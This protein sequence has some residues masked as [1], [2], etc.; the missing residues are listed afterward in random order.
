MPHP[1]PADRAAYVTGL[2]AVL[3]DGGRYFML[4]FSDREPDVKRGPHRFTRAEIAAWFVDGW[5]LDFIEPATIEVTID[6]AGRRAWLVGA[7]RVT[8]DAAR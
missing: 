6:P 2:A 5:Q 1:T 4:C 3:S 8:S 7:T